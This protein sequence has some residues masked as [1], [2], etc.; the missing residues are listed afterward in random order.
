M[1]DQAVAWVLPKIVHPELEY[2]K[3]FNLLMALRARRQKAKMVC[4]M[5]F[6]ATIDL[7]T[8][9]QLSCPY[10]STGNGT[11][12]RPA[13]VMKTP[14]HRHLI[15][16][17]GTELFLT[18][19]FSTGEPLLNK[20][21]NEVIAMTKGYE[22]FSVISTNL[23]VR[24]KDQQID[25]LLTGGLG[26]ISA[27]ID[28]AT[29][30]TYRQYRRGGQ[31]HLVMNNLRRL[32]DRKKELGFEYPLIEW[33][34]LLFRHN[35]DETEEA[36][37]LAN[38]IGVDTLE[39]FRGNAVIDPSEGPVLSTNKTLIGE[40]LTGPAVDRARA[41][42]DTRLRRMFG[43]NTRNDSGE[44]P[45][46]VRGHKCDWLYFGGM[47]YPSGAVGPCC[48]AENKADDFGKI[49]VASS[50]FVDIWNNE[51]YRSARSLFTGQSQRDTICSRCPLPSSQDYQF[52]NG[53]RGALLNAPDWVLKLLGANLELFFYEVDHWLMKP[54]LDAVAHAS[55]DI[56]EM[57]ASVLRHLRQEEVG[58]GGRA[59]Y[60]LEFLQMAEAKIPVA[61]KSVA[62]GIG[63]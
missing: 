27:S 34:F 35:Q 37:R 50:R 44:P 53:L 59:A 55:S 19:Y 17:F 26:M 45:N 18:W 31:F 10:C 9:C 43:G 33:R 52:R 49:D 14:L 28:G 40:S 12:D 6:E 36:R 58:G 11:I 38:E 41:R 25:E 47:L 21:F 16:T 7:S 46:A 48:V 57:P 3:Y 22:I 13:S 24:L 61:G 32:I 20:F 23:S 8:A 30:E 60:A 5:P 39:F 62:K 15:D 56:S 42:R 4:S 1:S 29:E 54:E 2:Q 51:N 63:Q